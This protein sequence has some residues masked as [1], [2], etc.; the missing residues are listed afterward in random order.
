MKSIIIEVDP[1]QPQL[2]SIKW[3]NTLLQEHL[4]TLAT[5]TPSLT[6]HPITLTDNLLHGYRCFK[7]YLTQP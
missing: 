7:N 4:A 5:T 3:N 1:N 2:I 6:L